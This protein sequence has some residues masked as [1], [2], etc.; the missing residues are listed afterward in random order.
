MP[1]HPWI[2]PRVARTDVAGVCGETLGERPPATGEVGGEFVEVRPRTLGVD[3]VRG[4]RRDAAQIVH[5]GV[6]EGQDVVAVDEVGR[7]LHRHTRVE[8]QSGDGDRGEELVGVRVVGRA[9]RGVRLGAEILDDHLL[10]VT[11]LAG[12]PGQREQTLR[13]FG[14]VLADPHEDPGGERHREA[15]RVGE[16]AQPYGRVLVRTAVVALAGG[17]EQAGGGGLEHHAHRRGDRLERGQLRP[18]H[19][20]RVEVW[21][22]TG[23][24]EHPDRHRA[25]VVQRR[26]EAARLEPLARLGPSVLGSVAEGEQCL[27]APRLRASAAE[28]DDLVGVEEHALARRAQLAGDGDEGAVVAAV[29]TQAGEGDEHLAGV[30]HHAGTSLVDE[31]GIAAGGRQ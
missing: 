20:A 10:Q 8:H 9:H 25:H 29:P 4:E 16:G 3:V 24:L 14:A 1:R 30:R 31:A 21:Q 13:P 11:E 23:L 15:A 12:E 17:R 22:Q 18:A 26:R 28:F 2:D 27:L 5:A 6:D 19:H 7:G